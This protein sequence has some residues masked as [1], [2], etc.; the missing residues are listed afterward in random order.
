MTGDD[1]PVDA[2]A[3]RELLQGLPFLDVS[4]LDAAEFDFFTGRFF[5]FNRLHESKGLLEVVP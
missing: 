4:I 1:F 2:A 5:A 3:E